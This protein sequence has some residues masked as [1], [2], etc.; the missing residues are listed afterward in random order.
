MPTNNVFNYNLFQRI[1]AGIKINQWQFGAGADF[2]EFGRSTLIAANNIG[3]FLRH[4][5]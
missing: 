3:I 2:N 5:F 1:R 4:E